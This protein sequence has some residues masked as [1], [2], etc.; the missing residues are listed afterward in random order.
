MQNNRPLGVTIIA[1]LAI[2]GGIGSLIGGIALVGDNTIPWCNSHYNRISLFW[3]CLWIMERIEMGL[4]NY[5][6]S[7][8]NSSHFGP[9]INHRGKCRSHY[10]RNNKCYYHLLSL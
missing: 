10:P 6:N 1:I 3:C 7:Y 5:I 2:L 8:C 9:C 4:V